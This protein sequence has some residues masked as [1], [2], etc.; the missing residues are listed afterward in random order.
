MNERRPEIIHNPGAIFDACEALLARV[1]KETKLDKGAWLWD[2]QSIAPQ[3]IVAVMAGCLSPERIDRILP[4]ASKL[5]PSNRAM[6]AVTLSGARMKNGKAYRGAWQLRQGD[7]ELPVPLASPVRALLISWLGD[8]SVEVREDAYF[9]LASEP[10]RKDE[11][12]RWAEL[13]SRKSS[14]M[15]RRAIERLLTLKDQP[16]LDLASRLAADKDKQRNAA[17]V[18]LFRVMVQAKRSEDKAAAALAATSAKPEGGAVT[19][20]SARAAKALDLDPRELSRATCFGLVPTPPQYTPSTPAAALDSDPSPPKKSGFKLGAIV[21]SVASVLAGHADP[22]AL[23]SALLPAGFLRITDPAWQVVYHFARIVSQNLDKPV[24]NDPGS[25]SDTSL[26]GEIGNHWLLWQPER[27]KPAAEQKQRFGLYEQLERWLVERTPD[28]RDTDGLELLRAALYTRIYSSDE[29]AHNINWPDQ[30]QRSARR[31]GIS[32]FKVSEPQVR[33]VARWALEMT[34]TQQADQRALE[35]VWADAFSLIAARK[36]GRSKHA[37]KE[38]IKLPPGGELIPTA[39]YAETVLDEMYGV[40]GN[41]AGA[42]L[43]WRAAVAVRAAARAEDLARAT[44]QIGTK[45]EY[46]PIQSASEYL[47]LPFKP[48]VETA[49]RALSEGTA[50]QDQF[51][52]TLLGGCWGDPHKM[53]SLTR[54]GVRI[55]WY[56]DAKALAAG[57]AVT[58]AVHR[59]AARIVELE[60]IRGEA[61]LP[62]TPFAQNLSYAGDAAV[63]VRCLAAL[64]GEHLERSRYGSGAD[65]L[66]ILS[67]FVQRTLPSNTDTPEHFA[68]LAAEAGLKPATL[69]EAAVFAPQWSRHVEHALN[70]PGLTDAIWWVH[71]HTKG[72]DWSI[73]ADVQAVWDASIAERTPIPADDLKAGSVDAPWFHRAH[74]A[75]GAE[76]WKK[77]YAA[78]KYACSGVGHKRAQLFADAMTGSSTAAQI[79]E[80][81]ETKRHQDSIRALGLCPLPQPTHLA[82]AKAEILRRYKVIQEIKRT[83]SKHGGSMLQASEKRAVERGLDNLARAAGHPDPLRLQWAMEIEQLGSLADGPMTATLDELTVTLSVID[84]EPDLVAMKK[85]KKLASIPAASKKDPAIAPLVELNRELGKSASRIRKALEEA[86]C[87]GD[88]FRAG[89]LA[90]L[91]RHPVLWPMIQRLLF[92]APEVG[93]TPIGYPD[94]NGRTLRDHAGK[95]EPLRDTDAL[96]LV[97]P[98]DLLTRGEGEWHLWQR[99][100][101]ASE[102]VQP[103]KQIFRELYLPTAAEG[104]K[105]T[106]VTRYAGQ[107]V[108]PRQALALLGTRGWVCA[109]KKASSAPSTRNAWSPG[110]S[111]WSPSTPRPMSKVSPSSASTSPAPASGS[112]WRSRTSRLAS[113]ARSCVT[114]IWSSPSPIAAASTPRPARAPSRAAAHWCARPPRCSAS[115]TSAST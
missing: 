30:I 15:R 20:S 13:L 74:A 35:A 51:V 10:L 22:S 36:I 108:Q 41:P 31:D 110:S 26:I 114:S 89:E 112:T 59:V 43:R 101:F 50:T 27:D 23:S 2:R 9:L 100:C 56:K 28:T 18:E 79:T 78:A 72:D 98:H 42:A 17:G 75:L 85:G 52:D 4:H 92:I 97:H 55:G 107:Q 6:L 115:R 49:A 37:R 11:V 87:R 39:S 67:R 111:S 71:A 96:R 95:K 102:R 46:T 103:F 48:T 76:R 99:D 14:D 12:E 45:G 19:P 44:E 64:D 73:D 60:L 104:P 25:A 16:L 91:S 53:H 69:V 8:P 90:E 113:S 57:A 105:E 62:S 70:W 5:E 34:R 40:A 29:L 61:P 81:I 84:G 93:S 24:Q 86:M 82:E 109:P 88:T 77:V 54:T 106:G 58:A 47:A 94:D 32:L 80:R 68:S 66:S 83:S 38:S 33:W 7:M 63:C 1:P 21:S 3:P 65:R